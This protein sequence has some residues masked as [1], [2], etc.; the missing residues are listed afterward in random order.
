MGDSG[1]VVWLG[2]PSPSSLCDSSRRGLVWKPRASLISG[3]IAST[4][5]C[6]R[7]HQ[8]GRP[9][10]R[11]EPIV[12]D[13]A[14]RGWRGSP[15]RSENASPL[16]RGR[17]PQRARVHERRV[18]PPR[19]GYSAAP[20]PKHRCSSITIYFDL[21][22][23]DRPDRCPFFPPTFPSW[24]FSDRDFRQHFRPK[25]SLFLRP[26]CNRR[27]AF[28]RRRYTIP[29]RRRHPRSPNNLSSRP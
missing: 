29:T 26:T 18:R 25:V 20:C 17:D 21:I 7:S 12:R 15:S 1:D 3:T 8:T 13:V 4:A 10:P 11:R 9:V 14:L 19:V 28:P 27:G 23:N 16:R 22:C 6:V 24:T 2:K 5:G